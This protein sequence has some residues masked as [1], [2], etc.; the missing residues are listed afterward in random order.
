MQLLYEAYVK[1]RYWP[2]YKIINVNT[3]YLYPSMTPPLFDSKWCLFDP[4][5]QEQGLV[6]GIAQ[7]E[8]G[9]HE[10]RERSPRGIRRF[11]VGSW[12]NNKSIL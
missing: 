9:D 8:G 4:P 5:H 11:A 3:N 7:L 10:A 6:G 1:L 2:S 12:G